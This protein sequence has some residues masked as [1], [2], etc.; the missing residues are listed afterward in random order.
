MRSPIHLRLR[1]LRTTIIVSMFGPVVA[2]A[3]PVT[4]ATVSL[5]Q[6]LELASAQA[7]ALGPSAA[8]LEGARAELE[9]RDRWFRFNPTLTL[10]VGPGLNR[11]RD[12]LD[13]SA[14]LSMPVEVAGEAGLRAASARRSVQRAAADRGLAVWEVHHAVHAGFHQA[15]VAREK[16][17]VE[18]AR[19][20]FQTEML[21]VV[22]RGVSAGQRSR[23]EQSLAEA[24]RSRA[25]LRLLEAK[26]RFLQTRLRLAE[27]V[28]WPGEEPPFPGGALDPALEPPPL[29]ALL[30]GLESQPQYLALSARVLEAEAEVSLRDREAWPVPR[31]GVAVN[32][33]SYEGGPP[34]TTV[35]GTIGLELPIANPNTEPRAR[36]RSERAVAEAQRLELRQLLRR[37]VEQAHAAVASAAARIRLFEA[38]LLPESERAVR[39]LRRSFELGQVDLLAGSAAAERL[40]GVRLEALDARARYFVAAEAL[41]EAFGRDPW[42]A[43]R[44]RHREDKP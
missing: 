23:L 33:E 42:P 14:S 29:E 41:E 30:E 34:E 24:E 4:T 5:D 3:G 35:L 40:F 10:G 32:R 38:S 25:E 19:L 20:A 16:L 6:L 37:R 21:D 12:H 13:Y 31:F 27:I 43:E 15:L 36:A 44:R 8:R 2:S 17:R 11:D 28:A 18:A 26:E 1:I 22:R 39:M 7:P 9:A